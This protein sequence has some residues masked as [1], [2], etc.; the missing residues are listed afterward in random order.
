MRN[1]YHFVIGSEAESKHLLRRMGVETQDFA[2]LLFI[3]EMKL[4]YP[5]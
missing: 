3:D 4:K 5:F 1:C 2:S